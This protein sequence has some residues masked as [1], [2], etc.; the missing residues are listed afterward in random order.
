[1][2]KQFNFKAK[3]KQFQKI[4]RTLPKRVGNVA[5]NHFLESWDNEGFSDGSINS[6]P[7]A[8]RDK[9][10]KGK[11]RKILIGKG[12]GILKGSMKLIPGAT[13]K[14]IAVGSYGIKYASRHNRGLDGMKKR[15]FI[16]KSRIL[17]KKIK[18][19]I[20]NEMKKLL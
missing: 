19:M 15:Q 10:P 17:D 4:N 3:I 9:E 20:R 13:F 16:G 8:K 6:D 5:L 2:A 7:W 1:M 12:T 11:K 18:Q 14:K